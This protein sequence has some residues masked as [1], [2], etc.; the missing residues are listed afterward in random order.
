MT[1]GD[2]NLADLERRMR[3]RLFAP[4]K[5]APEDERQTRMIAK[6][7]GTKTA[8]E[9]FLRHEK[10]RPA[11]SGTGRIA[12]RPK[13]FRPPQVRLKFEHWEANAAR[14]REWRIDRFENGRKVHTHSGDDFGKRDELIIRLQA[15]GAT[16]TPIVVAGITPRPVQGRLRDRPRRPSGRFDIM[17]KISAVTSDDVAEFHPDDIEDACYEGDDD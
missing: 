11:A 6:L 14:G 3:E 16:V 5:P 8:A 13:T 12:R 17:N 4:S 10:A 9:Q 7:L 1:E 15:A 2:D